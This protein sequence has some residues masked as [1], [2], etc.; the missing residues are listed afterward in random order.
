MNA[1]ASMRLVQNGAATQAYA[2][3]S[4]YKQ[5]HSASII[6][7]LASAINHLENHSPPALSNHLRGS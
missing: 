7:L 6:R 3:I 2:S 1:I 4:S 5:M